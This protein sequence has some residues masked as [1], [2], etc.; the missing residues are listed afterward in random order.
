M[1]LEERFW[2]KVD[3]SG[4]PD[5]CWTWT[6]TRT[7]TGYGM[8]CV[9]LKMVSSHRV[10]YS[11]ANGPIPDG[12]CVLHRCDNPPCV[13]PGHLWL[14]TQLQNIA[15]RD[16]K[17][18][19]RTLSGDESW[20]RKNPEKLL[21]GD[22]HPSRL[23]PERLARGER[24]GAYTKPHRV[25]RGERAGMAKLTDADVCSI[26][27]MGGSLKEVAALF[28]VSASTIHLIRHGQIWCH[29]A[30]PQNPPW[31]TPKRRRT[32]KVVPREN[33]AQE[34]R[35]ALVGASS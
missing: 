1:T 30:R 16:S 22:A 28:N 26:L 18:R 10:S 8:F 33:V 6:A 34:A 31:P 11:L 29:I 20:A 7:R 3:R 4:G 27:T 9:S 15:D 14:G 12:L 35:T 32:P 13:N 17:G 25:P 2:K 5:A 23:H 19:Q 24:N 21:R